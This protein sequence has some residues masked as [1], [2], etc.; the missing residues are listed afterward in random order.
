MYN[1]EF[2]TISVQEYNN[3][4]RLKRDIDRLGQLAESN[5]SNSG[6]LT[7]KEYDILEFVRKNP[8]ISKQGLVDGLNQQYSRVTVWN[9]VDAL[10]K[11]GFLLAKPD[12][13]NRQTWNLFVDEGNI[14]VSLTN[15]MRILEFLF[16]TIAKELTKHLTNP[17]EEVEVV[18]NA[19]HL[20]ID[21]A[22]VYSFVLNTYV[23]YAITEWTKI[24]EKFIHE[25]LNAILFSKLTDILHIITDLVGDYMGTEVFYPDQ[26]PY[27]LR[28]EFLIELRQKAN[29][30]GL[31]DYIDS[32]LD[33][34][35]DIGF[36]LFKKRA[37]FTGLNVLDVDEYK[38]WRSILEID[39]VE[40]SIHYDRELME[41]IRRSK[42]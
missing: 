39:I 9:T 36:E 40:D 25:R 24:K 23:I 1:S 35:W 14:L 17:N 31:Q 2:I 13:R 30:L 18:E 38:S 21:I 33:A 8:G 15:Q 27:L 10:L 41:Y 4:T 29:R 5:M 19:Y 32:L 26:I 6:G 12:A 28:K 34:T 37:P 3:L 16:S 22:F 7:N 42:T 20:S 11:F